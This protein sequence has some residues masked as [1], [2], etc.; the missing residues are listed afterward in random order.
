MNTT[1]YKYN[2]DTHYNASVYNTPLFNL[3][4]PQKVYYNTNEF[5]LMS[6]RDI[7]SA[8]NII[9]YN[10]DK[11]LG[12]KW[13]LP[14]KQGLRLRS[15]GYT[16]LKEYFKY[17]RCQLNF[18]VYCATSGLGLSHQ[19][20]TSGSPL[21][22]SFYRFHVMYH[23]RRVLFKLRANLPRDSN[24]NKFDNHYDLASYFQICAEYGVDPKSKWINGDWAYTAQ[25]GVFGS[26]HDF[27]DGSKMTK[28]PPT[29]NYCSYMLDKSYGLTQK[30]LNLISESVR[31]YIYLIL[32]AQINSRSNITS[33]ASIQIYT[34]EFEKMIIRSL[35]TS[36]DIARYQNII[37][38][39]KS[40]VD[41]PVAVGVYM[42]P[43]NMELIKGQK[44]NHFNNEILIAD[45][46]LQIGDVNV[47]IN[48]EKPN[49]EEKSQ[50]EHKPV[51]LEAYKND[52]HEE[53]KQSLIIGGVSIILLFI[54]LTRRYSG[55]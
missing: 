20:L 9:A 11:D 47:R 46:D 43:S 52:E 51:K 48:Q 39:T 50:L 7:F 49:M 8:Y 24:F 18:A 32:T 45:D 26:D 54:Y 44:T 21:L 53:E 38:Q 31:A 55:K 35:D 14:Y 6:Y 33:P 17:Y 12:D 37:S 13:A 25:W 1:I 5:I 41:F 15:I 28:A 23:I 29:P 36:A 30:A 34:D 4:Q 27:P 2:P 10:Y 16:N 22:K 40:K 19:H 42:M 3:K